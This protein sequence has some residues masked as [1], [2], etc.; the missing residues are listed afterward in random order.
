MNF[1]LFKSKTDK[2][3]KEEEKK[4]FSLAQKHD[5]QVD[6]IVLLTLWYDFIARY[7]VAIVIFFIVIKNYLYIHQLITSKTIDVSL[8]SVYIKYSTIFGSALLLVLGYWFSSAGA[9]SILKSALEGVARRKL[10]RMDNR[11]KQEEL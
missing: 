8:I 5:G 4:Y 11:Q 9:S 2:T 6:F 3:V 10:A 1:E 7:F